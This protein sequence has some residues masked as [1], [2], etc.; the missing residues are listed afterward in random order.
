M[1]A[2][3]SASSSEQRCPLSLSGACKYIPTKRSMT[4][5]GHHLVMLDIIWWHSSDVGYFRCWHLHQYWRGIKGRMHRRDGVPGFDF[6][7]QRYIPPRYLGASWQWV[8]Q[9]FMHKGGSCVYFAFSSRSCGCSNLTLVFTNF[10]AWVTINIVST[11]HKDR[12][13]KK[14][15]PPGLS[16]LAEDWGYGLESSWSIW[17]SDICSWDT[18]YTIFAT[19][20]I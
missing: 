16:V 20:T 17:S 4:S 7:E 2:S 19:T 5:S 14:Q 1:R 18:Y 3:T 13:T 10:F 11:A 12:S 8:C 9:E 6:I 15:G